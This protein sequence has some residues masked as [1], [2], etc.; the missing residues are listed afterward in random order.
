MRNTF[1]KPRKEVYNEYD[2]PIGLVLLGIWLAV[3]G[4]WLYKLYA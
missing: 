1:I 3:A 4:Y 2:I